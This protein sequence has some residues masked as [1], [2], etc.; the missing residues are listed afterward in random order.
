MNEETLKSA[1]LEII[2]EA[3]NLKENELEVIPGTRISVKKGKVDEFKANARFYYMLKNN[4]EINNDSYLKDVYYELSDELS[5]EETE[6]V[7]SK[8]YDLSVNKNEL[9]RLE[10]LNK[11]LNENAK[12]KQQTEAR[13]RDISTPEELEKITSDLKEL[14]ENA[15]ILKNNIIEI[16]TK[17]NAEVKQVVEEEMNFLKANYLNT[18]F[19]T[20][21]AILGAPWNVT[22]LKKDEETYKTLFAI[23]KILDNVNDQEQI[24]VVNNVLCVNPSQE[25]A[26]KEQLNKLNLFKLAEPI[27]KKEEFPK[28]ESPKEV[29]NILLKN[30]SEE[31]E[32]LRAKIAQEHLPSDQLEYDNL[33]KIVRY[34]NSANQKEFALTPVWNIAYINGIDRQAFIQLLR[35]TVYFE[36]ANPELKMIKE[37]ETLIA[38]LKNYLNEIENKFNH[39][40]G[41]YNIP[42]AQVGDTIILKEDEEEYRNVT[43][44]IKILENSKENLISIS[45]GG[46]VSYDFYPKYK[47]LLSKT[48]YFT[49]IKTKG[50]EEIKKQNAPIL[51]QIQADIQKLKGSGENNNSKKAN[52]IRKQLDTLMSVDEQKELAE[53]NGAII[54]KDKETEY[55][56][57]IE[58]LTALQ[59]DKSSKEEKQPIPNSNETTIVEENKP[60]ND[61]T[62]KEDTKIETAKE[63][64]RKR[65]VKTIRKATNKE[66]WKQNWQK[67]ALIGLSAIAI[68]FALSTLGPTLVYANSC[69]A[70]A[71]P[72]LSGTLGTINSMI[73]NAFGLTLGELNLNVAAAHALSA[74]VSA[75]ANLGVLGLGITGIVK[76]MKGQKQNR[77]PDP[78][79]KN[80]AQKILDLSEKIVDKSKNLSRSIRNIEDKTTSI[81]KNIIKTDITTEKE[82]KVEEE[83]FAEIAENVQKAI[84]KEQP[85][86]VQ[87]RINERYNRL[88]EEP[89]SLNEDKNEER[90]DSAQEKESFVT[91][92]IPTDDEIMAQITDKNLEIARVDNYIDAI[93]SGNITEAQIYQKQVFEDTGIDLGKYD[94]SKEEEII[95]ARSDVA[96]VMNQ[97]KDTKRS[98]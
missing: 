14:L 84:D 37:N 20:E 81:I 72:A 11:A 19:G 18:T 33:I 64:I 34:L 74:W 61:S 30:I 21:S 29:N 85:K 32:R 13:I 89:V 70:L 63:P 45:A 31:L 38:K 50:L 92:T 5:R 68:L 27:K 79:R 6:H 52:L 82:N 25:Q 59:N 87:D 44:I 4:V 26:I 58:E 46:N 12:K 77:L 90:K 95:Q 9:E 66:W 71:N 57:V 51:A 39:Y 94:M 54:N 91:V 8:A 28:V 78:E 83:K 67:V 73:I 88:K 75:A 65:A 43:E 10:N 16:K 24:I 93:K 40:S 7:L 2:K 22:V 41:K 1:L 96:N 49:P 62:M 55:K 80:I 36:N 53:V 86:D 69:L 97:A 60:L 47:E 76:G 15:T 23:S 3:E 35:N 56:K 42:V 98:R 48:K 17:V